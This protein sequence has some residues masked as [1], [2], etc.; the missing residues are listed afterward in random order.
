MSLLSPRLDHRAGF[1]D[2]AEDSDVSLFG[3]A[4]DA[5][6]Q[7]PYRQPR[8]VGFAA[9]VVRHSGER[10]GLDRRILSG[11]AVEA[12]RARE[13]LQ[14]LPVKSRAVLADAESGD[15]F[16]VVRAKPIRQLN[17]A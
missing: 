16:G 5:R 11:V 1:L 2:R 14:R 15:V 4:G 6:F 3:M 7:F 12:P 10:E 9:P 17:L 8:G 13:V